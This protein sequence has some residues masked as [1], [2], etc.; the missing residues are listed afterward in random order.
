MGRGYF[1]ATLALDRDWQNRGPGNI[2]GSPGGLGEGPEKDK[3]GR[4]E[5]PKKGQRMPKESPGEV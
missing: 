3:G 2:Q 4:Q 5:G 1:A